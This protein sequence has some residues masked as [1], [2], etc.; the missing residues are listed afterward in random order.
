[1][2]TGPSHGAL[3]GT[4]PN[5]TYTPANG[6]NGADTFQFTVTNKANLTSTATVSLT[7]A[8]GSPTA[9]A[10]SVNVAFNTGTA[11]TLSASDPNTTPVQ[12]P[13]SYAVTTG[14]SHGALTGTAPNLTYTP[15]NGFNGSD[16]F[17]F[18]VTNK[19]N[20]TSTATVSLT[21]APGSPTANAQS[22][23]V[24]F[25]TGTAITLTAS[26][27]N[28]TPV[29]TPLSYSVTTPPSHGALTGTAPNLTYTP[30]DGFN[31][32]DTFQFT[33]TNKANLTSTA[34]VSLTVTPGSPTANPQSVTVAFNTGIA[35]TLTASDPNIPVLA[36]LTF[37]LGAGPSHGTLTGAAPNLTY[38]PT[39]GFFGTDSFEFTV[40]NTANLVSATA[41]VS[42]TI[43]GIPSAYGQSVTVLFNTNTAITLT[44]TDPNIPSLTPLTYAVVESPSHGALTGAL[45]NL[46]YTPAQGF[47]GADSFK[48]QVT[49]TANLTSP[50]ATVSLSVVPGSPTANTQSVN[51]AFETETAITL[52]AS[53][54]NTTPVQTPLSYAVTTVPSHGS[55]AGTAPNLIYTPSNGF[56]GADSLQ[57]TVTNKANLTSTATIS[58]VVA[59]GSPPEI[60]SSA[61]ATPNP[62]TVGQQVLLM[63]AAT[64]PTN[65]SLTYVWDFGDGSHSIGA[66]VTH[67]YSDATTYSATVTVIDDVTL[68]TTS[69]TVTVTVNAIN[70]GP[71][72][73]SSANGIPDQM[74]AAAAQAG[75]VTISSPQSL[76]RP[77]LSIK[78][79]FARSQNDSIGLSGFMA[80][81]TVFTPAGQPIIV[82]VGGVVTTFTLSAQGKARFGNYTFAVSP[83]GTSASAKFA[84]RLNKGSFQ[85]ILALA[86]LTNANAKAKHVAIPIGIIF[87]DALLVQN[88]SQTY[89]A[90]KGKLGT[91]KDVK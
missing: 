55:L 18:T 87:A 39:N 15:T 16:S 70:D 36:P 57:F 76:L 44:G 32:E 48:F 12:T 88:Q 9:N 3:T 46:I 89:T 6:F 86:G 72:T 47:N 24:A 10:Q 7:V 81:P 61:T 35:I 14:T 79:D 77:K 68:A 66:T 56:N 62:V 4:A 8:P 50:T 31:G 45:P 69:A 64:G 54:P 25:N 19:A 65:D 75:I 30:A 52:T 74:Q 78:L 85:G 63:V 26:D 82:D 22:V 13:L 21:I 84:M 34:T 58:L 37:I 40:A 42:L 17:Q 27:P 53:D 83:K 71:L 80:R 33:V 29:Q 11:I 51:V 20:L 28:T 60:T 38:T 91:T 90:I 43:G 1:V 2:T 59:K 49:N 67:T 5:L 23:N 73:I 41:T